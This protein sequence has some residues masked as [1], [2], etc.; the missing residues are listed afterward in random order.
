MELLQKTAK[1]IKNQIQDFLDTT[2]YAEQ[3]QGL[4]SLSDKDLQDPHIIECFLQQ[5]GLDSNLWTQYLG[6]IKVK[7][8]LNTN[9]YFQNLD[10]DRKQEFL[11]ADFEL[12]SFFNQHGFLDKDIF[13]TSKL[14]KYINLSRLSKKDFLDKLLFFTNK[15]IITPSNIF[16]VPKDLFFF[17]PPL[18]EYLDKIS[19]F[20]HNPFFDQEEYSSYVGSPLQ[21]HLLLFCNNQDSTA[22]RKY[23]SLDTMLD[24]KLPDFS[25]KLLQL[26]TFTQTLPIKHWEA[27]F[28]VIP[29]IISKENYKNLLEKLEEKISFASQSSMSFCLDSILKTNQSILFIE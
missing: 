6:S 14:M 2:P 13:K 26:I 1:E 18:I 12:I 3:L 22:L 25:E 10:P 7:A 29:H 9:Q 20:D 23:E 11:T 8:L 27:F 5:Q 28:K 17:S 4:L 16:S 15:K 19:F 21:Q 24:Y